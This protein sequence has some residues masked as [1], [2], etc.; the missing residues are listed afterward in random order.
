MKRK[1]G[2]RLIGYLT[3]DILII[4]VFIL[5]IISGSIY[6]IYVK[7]RDSTVFVMLN[8]YIVLDMKGTFEMEKYISAIYDYFKQLLVIWV[9]GLFRFTVPF[10]IMALF[11]TVFSYAFTTTC[12]ILVY[13]LKGIIVVLFAYGLQAIIIIT[14]S[15]Y[16]VIDS[17][18]KQSLKT[19]HSFSEHIIQIIPIAMGS[20]IVALIDVLTMTNLHN[21]IG[22]IL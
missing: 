5:A 1:Y 7:D 20:C 19:A 13:G 8:N 9:F 21:V 15:M 16:L 18:R 10:S 11:A 6:A 14:I 22:K 4:G 12:A 2:T 17:L 3:H